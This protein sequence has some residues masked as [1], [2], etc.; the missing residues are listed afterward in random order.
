MIN[1]PTPTAMRNMAFYTQGV[2]Q[3]M[4]YS[5]TDWPDHLHDHWITWDLAHDINI[6]IDS[7]NPTTTSEVR[8]SVYLRDPVASR[9]LAFWS[10]DLNDVRDTDQCAPRG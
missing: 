9:T 8:A 10:L 6:W 2:I 7:D 4:Q 1:K 5:L 3:G